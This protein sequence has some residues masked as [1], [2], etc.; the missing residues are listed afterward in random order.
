MGEG[1]RGFLRL[2]LPLT[3]ASTAFV[4]CGG[5]GD[6]DAPPSDPPP[7][8]DPRAPSLSGSGTVN[9]VIL[10]AKP[11]D[12]VAKAYGVSW[13]EIEFDLLDD[14]G[15]EATADLSSSDATRVALAFYGHDA[16]GKPKVEG[17]V[18]M[19]LTRWLGMEQEHDA[20]D[21][22]RV[23]EGSEARY[24]NAGRLDEDERLEVLGSVLS[25]LAES[26][27]S[28]TGK[29]FAG[30]GLSAKDTGGAS[31]GTC[32]GEGKKAVKAAL[33]SIGKKIA[34]CLPCASAAIDDPSSSDAFKACGTCEKA[35][36][37]TSGL[38]PVLDFLKCEKALVL[39][40]A[41]D[42]TWAARPVSATETTCFASSPDGVHG[43]YRV[44]DGKGGV[45]C[46]DCPSGTI[47]FAS[48]LGCAPEGDASS[49][50]DASKAIVQ[51]PGARGKAP[52]TK[53]ITKDACVFVEITS[54]GTVNSLP[55]EVGPRRAIYKIGDRNWDK[56][57]SLVKTS[58]DTWDLTTDTHSGSQKG[59]FAITGGQS[60]P[61]PA[62]I[63]TK[64]SVDDAI[65]KGGCSSEAVRGLSL[66]I[67]EELSRC[68]KPDMMV[69]V[70]GGGAL[71]TS[72]TP[73]PYLEK[74]AAEALV[75]AV[76]A[77]KGARLHVNHMFRTV[78]QQYFISRVGSRPECGIKA[79]ARPGA[80][81]HETGIALDVQD[82]SS[83][84][85]ALE[86][87][88]FRWLGSK[89]PVHF[90][91]VGAGAVDL[92]GQDVLA[93]QRLWNRNHPEDKI[94]EDGKYG[95]D[96][97]ARI[98]KAP[99]AGFPIGV[100]ES[101]T[102]AK[103]VQP[104]KGNA[105]PLEYLTN[106]TTADLF[107]GE[108]CESGHDASH[109]DVSACI[110]SKQ[111]CAPYWCDLADLRAPTCAG[112]SKD[113]KE[114]EP[115]PASKPDC[116]ALGTFKL[117][118]YYIAVE[119]DFSGDKTVPIYS[120]AGAVLATVSPKFAKAM[121][122]E[123]TGRLNDGRALN[124]AGSCVHSEYDCYAELDAKYSTGRGAAGRALQPYHS[125]AVDPSVI[126]LGTRLYSPE[127]AGKTMPDGSTHDGYL[128]ADDTGGAIKGNHI[129]F[130]VKDKAAYKSLNAALGLSNV[131]LVPATCK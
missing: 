30:P 63:S 87:E 29:A 26:G 5:G 108:G 99:A 74:P 116:A 80:S 130:F 65:A 9:L 95:A 49:P 115:T 129:D 28:P 2:L 124:W 21:I 107:P 58:K 93:F 55:V 121:R 104:A 8:D 97:E 60:K 76:A 25:T 11:T 39:P 22:A 89:D 109:T 3:L 61:P 38:E 46:V 105:A 20:N 122:L 40:P 83:W 56:L 17:R 57:P 81:N 36:L 41:E 101:C 123:G 37:D 94:G 32:D 12:A 10:D 24:S 131:T 96:T 35:L 119:S 47:P 67:L 92:R 112:S 68:V 45:A 19:D 88:G 84:R 106:V 50:V 117:T 114:P 42:D 18:V 120:R 23:F 127:L 77:R 4:A 64:G 113:S 86:A 125:I 71:D 48:K 27:V 82:A 6:S 7:I 1:M 14:L 85:A 44:S 51:I 33:A 79:W 110:A 43:T 15:S 128:L 53:V 90:D 111:V 75:R 70:P 102:T 66:Q 13:W 78:A 118:Y 62:A 100:P 52:A 103:V 72:G 73:N 54:Q 91:Y 59:S 69:Q 98:R 126:A 16:A 34:G 31:L